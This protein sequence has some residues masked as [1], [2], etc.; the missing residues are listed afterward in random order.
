MIK[1]QIK[2]KQSGVIE[3]YL[4]KHPES[5]IILLTT[6]KNTYCVVSTHVDINERGKGIGKSLYLAM[7]EF[8]RK[9]HAKFS[10]TCPFIAELANTDKSVKDV[11]IR[12]S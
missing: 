2:K 11:Y 7:I 1:Y 10:A 8:I 6:A 9:Q 4:D 5:R 12:Q 3:L